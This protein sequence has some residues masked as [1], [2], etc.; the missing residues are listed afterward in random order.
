MGN[1]IN[2]YENKEISFKFGCFIGLFSPTGK[3]YQQKKVIAMGNL[4]NQY[5]KKK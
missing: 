4:I 5:E 2:Q 1:L 3:T